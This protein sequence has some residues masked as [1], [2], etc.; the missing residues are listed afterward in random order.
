MWRLGAVGK[1]EEARSAGDKE[2]WEQCTTD[3][4]WCEVDQKNDSSEVNSYKANTNLFFVDLKWSTFC[5]LFNFYILYRY[6]FLAWVNGVGFIY[7]TF[8]EIQSQQQ[9][10]IQWMHISLQYIPESW[11]SDSFLQDTY[12][13]F[14]FIY[15]IVIL[16]FT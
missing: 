3:P 14:I 8:H 1:G 15:I 7:C 2:L 12:G 16:L 6:F 9:P 11:K 10:N 4:C 13:L 5:I